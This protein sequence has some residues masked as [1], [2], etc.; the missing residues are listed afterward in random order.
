MTQPT[1]HWFSPLP[2][3][4]TDIGHFTARILPSLSEIAE[5]VVWT[6]TRNSSAELGKFCKVRELEKIPRIEEMHRAD[7]IFYNLGNHGPFHAAILR[8]AWHVPG[9]VVLHE[10]DLHGLLAYTWV[11]QEH[12]SERYLAELEREHGKAG[13]RFGEAR[14]RGSDVQKDLARMPLLSAAIA[15]AL[16]VICHTD[17]THKAASDRSIPVFQTSLPFASSS[18]KR[19][20]LRSGPLRLLQFGYLNPYRRTLEILKLISQWPRRAEVRFDIAGQLWDE[21][22]VRSTVS[23]LQLDG[24][25]SIHGYLEEAQLNKR[26]AEADLVLNLRYPTLGE[27]SGSQLRIWNASVPSVV[28]SIGWFADLP[29]GSVLKISPESESGELH[30][31]LE[32]LLRDRYC[33]D[34][35][36]RYGRLVLERM[37]APASYARQIVQAAHEIPNLRRNAGAR[38]AVKAIAERL[39]GRRSVLD[40]PILARP[41]GDRICDV[42]ASPA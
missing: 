14:L 38:M 1:I 24:I 12:D 36:G 21:R 33:F 28:P 31:I 3:D 34:H 40:T 37:H 10:A 16:A 30:A 22:L 19:P 5:I 25:V 11:E 9:I 13:R 17:Q 4:R 7:S 39:W 8:H 18:L 20:S 6:S 32:A 42:F 23:K 35:I 27:A 15:N 26:I 2:P 41:A 29:E